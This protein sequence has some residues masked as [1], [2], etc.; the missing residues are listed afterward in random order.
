MNIKKLNSEKLRQLKKDIEIELRE[1]RDKEVGH[2]LAQRRFFNIIMG[3]YWKDY[4]KDYEVQ[5]KQISGLTEEEFGR[6]RGAGQTVIDA[7]KSE[8]AKRNLSFKS[9]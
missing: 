2:S 1:R 7:A 3:K 4:K 8:L 9:N 6:Y 5:L